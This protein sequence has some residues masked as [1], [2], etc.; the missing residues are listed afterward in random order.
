MNNKHFEI[1]DCTLRDGGYCNDWQFSKELGREVYRA[2]SK[3][4]VDYVELGFRNPPGKA[5]PKRFGLWRTS[6]EQDLAEAVANIDGAKVAIMGDYTSVTAD[7]FVDC[8]NS[9]A[10]MVRI[11]VNKDNVFNAIALLDEL[12]EKGYLTSLQC[13]GYSRYTET[14]KQE[15]QTALRSCGLDYF[16]LADSYGSIFPFHVREL[17]EPYIG[18]GSFKVGFHPHNN[19]QMA[20]ANTLAAIEVGVDIVDT[21]IYGIG[22]GAGNLPTEILL[23]YLY[24]QGVE[25]YNPIPVLN[26]VER[27]FVQLLQEHPWGYQL[28]YMISGVFNAHPNYSKALLD[29]KEYTIEDIWRGM[30]YIQ[31]LNPV[32]FKPELIDR[33]IKQG[34]LQPPEKR[35][36]AVADD[37][38]ESFPEV[39]YLDRHKG[40]DFLVL[41]LGPTIKSCKPQIERFIEQYEPVVLGANFLDELYVPHYHAFTS[42]KR[43]VSY[44]ETVNSASRLLVG[45]NIPE[46]P[47]A[48]HVHREYELLVFRDV[49]EA[50]F[51]IVNGVIMA[52]CR[53]VSVLLLGVALAMGAKRLFAV[54]LDG[55]LGKNVVNTTLYYEEQMDVTSHNLN[56]ERH[57]SNERF[58]HQIDQYVCRQGG[59]GV[60][61]LTPTSYGSFY[62]GIENYIGR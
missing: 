57:R 46:D 41:G 4:G 48:E 33:L 42:Q 11:A 25:G 49:L 61:I 38:G 60:H 22:R 17:F 35:V 32:G 58:L 55:Y 47:V 3:S 8:K 21:T 20:F 23:A 29:R 5:D 14:E 6:T 26:S 15:L 59:E 30:E 62:K 7:D 40:R 2:L 27:F 53:T 28:P 44:A 56:L 45:V 19:L 1:L 54:G 36:Q 43:L 31:E 24:C 13:M 12:K 51:D 50:D 37:A 39:G 9:I 52:N 18:L 34:L 16:Y 10:D